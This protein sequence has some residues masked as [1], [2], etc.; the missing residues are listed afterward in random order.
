VVALAALAPAANGQ[1]PQ[2]EDPSVATH[3]ALLDR[4]CVTCHNE[5][6][7]IPESNPLHLD[8]LD[9]VA[10]AADAG[11]W[12][13][14]A[15][16]LRAG[17]MPPPGRPQPDPAAAAALATWLETG[18]D[19][20]S[21]ARPDPGP[22][23]A[24]RRLTR[25]EYGNAIRDLLA[26]E[27]LPRELD[28]ASLLPADNTVGFDNVAE[29]LFVTPT[30]LEAYITAARKIAR[31]A[32][33][34]PS[35]PLI[36]DTYPLPLELPQDRHLPGL[37]LGTRGGIAID[38]FFPLDGDYDIE[39]GLT[40]FGREPDRLEIA[41]DG[42]RVALVVIGGPADAGES[43]YDPSAGPLRRRVR[44]LSGARTLGVTFAGKTAAAGETLVSPFSRGRGRM[45]AVT[46]VT[47]SG[48][49]GEAV[50]GAS[51]SRAR[52]FTCYPVPPAADDPACARR[53]VST[54]LHRAYRRTVTEDDLAPVLSFY[55]AGHAEA[56]FE[57]GVQRALERI[58]VSPEFLLRVEAP[59]VD[60]PP[61]EAYPVTDLELATRLAFFLWSSLPDDE[62]LELGDAGRLRAPGVLAD[63][64]TRMLADP[65]ATSLVSNFVA[66]WLY[67]RDLGAR[68][69]NDRLFPDFD[70]GL[71]DALLG[72]TELVFE[73]LLREDRS[74]LD[75]LTPNE[76]FLNERLARHYGIPHVYGSHFRRVSLGDD[77]V[78]G[79]LLGMGSIL[80]LTSYATRTS[81]VVR[82]KWVLENI[83][84][85]PPPP[86]PPD[87]PAL[88]DTG[89]DGRVL[90]MRDRMAQHRAN[91]VCASCHARMDP[92]GLALENLDAVGRWRTHDES[93][94]PIDASGVLPDGTVFEGLAGL[95]SILA[96]RPEAF[97][98]TFT[99]KLLMYAVGRELGAF[100]RPTIRQIVREAA[101]HDYRM[102]AIVQAIVGSTPFQM[103]RPES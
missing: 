61:G 26:L 40:R 73:T 37:P 87:V 75:L 62:L 42:E 97:V 38:R 9:L 39:I 2:T 69:P 77:S 84:G 74:V 41:V 13:L 33:G 1:P 16:K 11:A 35:Q 45:P 47:I 58:L 28:L 101:G 96:A 22:Q 72:E 32:V 55:D 63:Q 3:A 88:R 56:G 17:T 49:Y 60:G 82:G 20:A 5:R 68:R 66:Q 19:R 90:S 48:P 59:A 52:I 79:G 24:V 83:L 6:R 65:R 95:R 12:E 99:E 78:R 44:V 86:P 31:L 51:A 53:V 18:L 93:G 91:P 4:F 103:R 29:L 57:R 8:R 50:P 7:G 70:D 43:A 54:L 30:L 14:V 92:L 27:A 23:P 100:D 46:S 71:R 89:D 21:A 34:D 10:V 67:L 102:S 36:V 94:A 81:P 15:G 80:T 25:T 85:A 98:T 64:V 76:T